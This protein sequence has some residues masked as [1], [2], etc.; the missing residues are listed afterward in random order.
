MHSILEEANGATTKVQQHAHPIALLEAT[1][2][3]IFAFLT[4]LP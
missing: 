1:C 2:P 3:I 4:P